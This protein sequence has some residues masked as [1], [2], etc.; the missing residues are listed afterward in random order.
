VE[1]AFAQAVLGAGVPI[2]QGQHFAH[3]T[4]IGGK[5]VIKLTQNS[6]H[7]GGSVNQGHP[8]AEFGQIQCGP[9]AAYSSPH[10]QRLTDFS[11]HKYPQMNG[12]NSKFEY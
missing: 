8:I 1:Q 9:D 12:K 2:D 4:A 5:L 10:N 7:V 11:V 6:P 3:T